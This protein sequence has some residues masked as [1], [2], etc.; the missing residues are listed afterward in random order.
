MAYHYLVGVLNLERKT[1][2]TETLSRY[3]IPHDWTE[4]ETEELQ[5]AA[6]P[7][8]A[9]ACS[10]DG[11]S[12]RTINR[13][14]Y[15]QYVN[16]GWR[17]FATEEA[18][19]DYCRPEYAQKGLVVQEVRGHNITNCKE[20]GWRIFNTW[21]EAQAACP[22]A[23]YVCDTFD[24][25]ALP[26]RVAETDAGRYRGQGFVIGATAEEATAALPPVWAWEDLA[27][28]YIRIPKNTAREYRGVPQFFRARALIRALKNNETTYKWR[29]GGSRMT[30]EAELRLLHYAVL[31]SDNMRG[32]SAAFTA[33]RFAESMERLTGR[34]FRICDA[35]NAY[36]GL[37][38]SLFNT[39]DD[40]D[41]I[42]ASCRLSHF[43]CCAHCE[44][45]FPIADMLESEEEKWYCE[46]HYRRPAAPRGG[47]LLP[48]RSN[49]LTRCDGFLTAR[50][51]RKADMWLG[52]ELECYPAAREDRTTLTECIRGHAFNEFAIVKRDSTIEAGMEIVSIP[53]TLAW[54]R[55][56]TVSFLADM[57]GRIE[58]WKHNNAG[59]HVHVGREQLSKL[60]E[61][62]VTT[63]VTDKGSQGFL[64]AVA[65]REPNEYALRNIPRK[66]ST[67][68]IHTHGRYGAINFSTRGEKTMEWRIFRSNV[69]PLGFLK[70]LELV[71]AVTSWAKHAGNFQVATK[72]PGIRG[73]HACGIA[74]YVYFLDWLNQH[75]GEYPVLVKWCR[76]NS[77]MEGG[78]YRSASAAA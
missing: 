57:K 13:Y 58:G 21:E 41:Q 32:S 1:V 5:I 56:N 72:Q 71:H 9:F 48:Y 66:L 49:V 20:D 68:A 53:A 62:R 34:E 22:A 3:L 26:V 73:S 11:S 69:S 55:E 59:M 50:A 7:D 77:Y 64:T 76:E 30:V 52:W 67:P 46:Q 8:T 12:H 51:E 45:Y 31:R 19:A 61:A 25:Y 2:R 14:T 78:T 33:S 74:G 28:R 70:N 17:L 42:C 18:R 38:G 23:V 15:Q 65:G 37:A 35:C 60:Q 10:H 54:H 75:R 27:G 40:A 43:R 6:S 36:C 39:G 44:I 24:G 16:S 47:E 29:P 4:Y 63:F